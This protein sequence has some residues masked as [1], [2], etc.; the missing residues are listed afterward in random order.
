MKTKHRLLAALSGLFLAVP[1]FAQQ[2]PI[3][4]KPADVTSA[5]HGVIMHPEYA[6]IIGR[7]A[8]VWGWPMVNQMN[9][10]AAITQAPEPGRLNGVL[11]VAPRGQVGMLNDYIAEIGKPYASK[12]GF[13]LLVGPNW[14]GEAPT[15]V[16]AVIRS[17]TELA[18]VIPR[19]FMDDTAEDRK[20]V[21]PLINQI[22][23]YPLKDFDGKTKTIDWSKAPAIPGQASSGGETPWVV[24]EKFFDQLG[25]VLDAVP[26]LP[27]EES[28]YGNFRA[29]LDAASK[30]PAIKKALDEVAAETESDDTAASRRN[31][32]LKSTLLR[33]KNHCQINSRAALGYF[34]SNCLGKNTPAYPTARSNRKCRTCQAPFYT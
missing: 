2:V 8:Y 23:A 21:Q 26:P 30:D 12:P 28:L 10:R 5:A 19:V 4:T 34:L 3:A 24:P 25:E 33:G 32:A 15:G 29:L 1:S 13:Y 7:M 22:V 6:K 18:N 9:R 16:N 14:K 11:P 27:G 20:A 31:P 17:S